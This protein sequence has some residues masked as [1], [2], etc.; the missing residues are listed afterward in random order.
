MCLNFFLFIETKIL[1]FNW[2][3]RYYCLIR[4][5]LLDFLRY[6]Q[7]FAFRFLTVKDVRATVMPRPI[8]WTY[9]SGVPK[10][11]RWNRRGTLHIRGTGVLCRS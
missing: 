2:R 8:G 11:G 4:I 6:S 5:I 7:F 3:Y 9:A 10:S 1:F